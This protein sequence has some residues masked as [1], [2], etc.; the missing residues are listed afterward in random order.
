M[1]L[2]LVFFF[3]FWNFDESVLFPSLRPNHNNDFL[4]QNKIKH[5]RIGQGF[6]PVTLKIN[7]SNTLYIFLFDM[8]F[9][10]PTNRL[11][12]FIFLTCISNLVQIGCF[13]LFDQ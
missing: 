2:T 10:N 7:P 6:Y 5:I 4:I 1:G 12:F 9:E 8:N 3:F 13:V 11:H